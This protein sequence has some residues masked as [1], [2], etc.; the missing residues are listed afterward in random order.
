LRLS[1]GKGRKEGKRM[2]LGR[3]EKRRSSI[4]LLKKKGRT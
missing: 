2:D 4:W 3:D 1:R